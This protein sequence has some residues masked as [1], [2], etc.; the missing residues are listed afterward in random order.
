VGE[1]TSCEPVV[2]CKGA[3]RWDIVV[4]GKSAHT[5]NPHEGVNA[6]TRMAQ[7]L[8]L[9][10]ECERTLLSERHHPLVSRRTLTPALI[11]GGDAINVVPS[12]CRVS[13]DLRTLPGENA[14]DAQSVV[15]AFLKDRSDFPIEHEN[16]QLW[17]GADTKPDSIF[18]QTCVEA[19]RA[20]SE[21][22]AAIIPKGVNY[23]CHASDYD[24][25]GISAVV[26]GPGDIAVAHGIDEYVPIEDVER[27][28]DIY[29]EIMTSP[30]A[31]PR[32]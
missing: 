16:L 20:R 13:V 23:G 5:S 6:I 24:S 28:V 18:V 4:R 30:L 14:A 3:A 1:P 2:A 32:K 29:A 7:V 10:E 22:P 21:R 15:K 11:Q 12:S 27:M 9:L 17:H 8:S 31:A 19:C 25:N 26:I